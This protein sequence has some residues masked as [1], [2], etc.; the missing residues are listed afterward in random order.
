MYN[1]R[2]ITNYASCPKLNGRF[3]WKL[4]LDEKSRP[5]VATS[6]GTDARGHYP[7]MNMASIQ[8][9]GYAMLCFMNHPQVMCIARMPYMPLSYLGCWLQMSQWARKLAMNPL[10]H[11][12][13]VCRQWWGARI[14]TRKVALERNLKHLGLSENVGLIFPMIASHL[15]TGFHDQQNQTGYNGVHNIFRHT[16]L[17]SQ[18]LISRDQDRQVEAGRAE[19]S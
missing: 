4:A 7:K 5:H 17:W 6:R 10:K 16:H 8:V 3:N 19:Q 9:R 13:S 14:A 12:K 11:G 1:Y 2:T 18:S 15:K